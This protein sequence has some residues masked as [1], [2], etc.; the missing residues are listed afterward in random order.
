MR[1]SLKMQTHREMEL[2]TSQG[3][4]PE[5]N[6]TIWHNICMYILPL[7]MLSEGVMFLGRKGKMPAWFSVD[8][9]NYI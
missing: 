5:K 9:D 3:K 8:F 6:P 1:T 4:E 7:R 2:I